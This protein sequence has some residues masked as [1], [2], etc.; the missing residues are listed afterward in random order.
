MKKEVTPELLNYNKFPGP[1]F[2]R[3]GDQVVSENIEFH[4]REDY[5]SAFD[6]TEFSHRFS[7][8]ML[9]YDY[10]VGDW[11]HEQ[12][13]LKGF[14]KEE[15]AVKA[16]KKISHL[17]DYLLEYC[18]F[19]CAYF[20]LENEAPIQ[21]EQDKEDQPRRKRRRSSNR[22]NHS[23]NHPHSFTVKQDDKDGKSKRRRPKRDG[24]EK[25]EAGEKSR[26]N[27]F[28]IRQK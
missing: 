5:R 28:V 1:V 10:I 26:N 4:L 13:R 19:G 3:V 22:Q 17:E 25:R 15:R 27:R 2:A 16:A 8:W 6:Q 9:Q 24:Q 14:Y 23:L 20:V 7:N 12:L 11:G 21:I 18:N